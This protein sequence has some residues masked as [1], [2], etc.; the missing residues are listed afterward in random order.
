MGG[1]GIIAGGFASRTMGRG[2]LGRLWC[3]GRGLGNLVSFVLFF[4]VVVDAGVVGLC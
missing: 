3:G 2:I 4:S 1:R